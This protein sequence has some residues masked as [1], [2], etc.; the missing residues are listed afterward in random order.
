ME[1]ELYG[2]I[3]GRPVYWDEIES[4]SVCTTECTQDDYNI[5]HLLL[6]DGQEIEF[7]A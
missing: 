3:F 6:K 1:R 2:I 4:I 7:A 5:V